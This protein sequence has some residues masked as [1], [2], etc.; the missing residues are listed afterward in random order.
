MEINIRISKTTIG[1]AI[2][3]VISASFM[4]QLLN[5]LES[6]IGMSGVSVILSIFFLVGGAVTSLYLYKS[7][8][9]LW[10]IFLFGGVLAAGF[11]YAWQ[12][13]IIAERLHLIKY[14]LLGWLISKDIIK[15]IKIPFRAL[16]AV[17]FCLS[18]SGVDEIYQFFLPWRVGDIRDV[19]FAGV[20]GIW[21]ITLFLIIANPAKKRCHESSN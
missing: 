17:L 13:K 11:F 18:V 12:M 7:R 6:S 19:L 16:V 15:P 20:G 3:I 8:P 10:K 14:G 4:R 1:F 5:F 2:F 9:A 21:G